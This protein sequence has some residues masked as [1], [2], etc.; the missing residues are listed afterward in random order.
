[1]Q[2]QSSSPGKSTV[3]QTLNKEID[4]KLTRETRSSREMQF[5][6]IVSAAARRDSPGAGGDGSEITSG[7]LGEAGQGSTEKM[8][9]SGEALYRCGNEGCHHST[10]TCVFLR[11]HLQVCSVGSGSPFLCCYHCGKQ[12]RQVSSLLDHLRV[13]GP[14]RFLCGVEGC[15][16]KTTMLHNFKYHMKQDHQQSGYKHI[17]KDP[18]NKDPETQA[19][20]VY[21]K[22]AIPAHV[23]THRKRKNE[24]SIEDLNRIPRPSI[25][26]VDLK[27]Y[28]CTFSSKVRLNLLKHLQLHSKYPNGIP[29]KLYIVD[30]K[31]IP[32]PGKQPVNPVPC[33]HRKEMMFDTMMNLA[34][35]SFSESKKKKEDE[36][37]ELRLKNPIPVEELEAIPKFIEEKDL[38]LCRIDGCNY[39]S[40]DA[41]MLKY[42]I[43]TL[44][45]D[46][47]SFPCPHCKHFIIT[48]EKMS[49]HFRL[50]GDHLYRCGWCPYIA[51]KRN[52]VERHM[53]EKHV[54]K[55]LFDF[56][57]REPDD[58]NAPKPPEEYINQ[59]KD[60]TQAGPPQKPV[61]QCGMCKFS[62][63]T[64]QE[65]VNHTSLKHEIKSQYKCGYCNVRS[66]VRASF[67]AHFAAKH[68]N[69]EFRVLCMYYRLDS[70]D[71]VP[72]G[73]GTGQNTHEPLWKRND[74]ERIKHIRGILLDDGLRQKKIWMDHTEYG[75]PENDEF[76]CPVCGSFKNTC[77]NTFRAHLCKEAN[78]H[79]YQCELCGITNAL[80]PSL[81]AHY[82][83]THH[84]SFNK[85][86][87]IDLPVEDEKEAW[88][89]NIISHQQL[90][91]KKWR[92]AGGISKKDIPYS[93]PRVTGGSPARAATRSA[94]C[95]SRSS[96]DLSGGEGSPIGGVILHDSGSGQG[97]FTC[98]T[99]AV[100]CR[101]AAG[102]KSHIT[103]MHQARFK[104]YYCPFSSNTETA[105]KQHC[106]NK[107]PRLENK[108]QDTSLRRG[109]VKDENTERDILLKSAEDSFDDKGKEKEIQD[110]TQL[111]PIK[112][113]F[114]NHCDF[115]TSSSPGYYTHMRTKH[116]AQRL[117]RCGNC[118]ARFNTTRDGMRHN[119]LKHPNLKAAIVTITEE[120]QAS[121]LAD[122]DDGDI[123]EGL[124]EESVGSSIATSSDLQHTSFVKSNKAKTKKSF[125]LQSYVKEDPNSF[126]KETSSVVDSNCADECKMKEDSDGNFNSMYNCCHCDF[127][128]EWLAVEQHVKNKHRDLPF[129]V[130]KELADKIV[131]EVYL[132]PCC[133][134]KETS[135]SLQQSMDHW[136][137]NH[138]TLEFKPLIKLHHAGFV[139]KPKVEVTESTSK[140]VESLSVI[141]PKLS[142]IDTDPNIN[143]DENMLKSPHQSSLS[144]AELEDEDLCEE[145]TEEPPTADGLNRMAGSTNANDEIIYRCGMCKKSS[146]VKDI[147]EIHQSTMH[148]GKQV[149]MREYTR[150]QYNQQFQ[151][152]Y[153]CGH[154]GEKGRR[155]VMNR[156]SEKQHPDLPPKL[157]KVKKPRT[158]KKRRISDSGP[159]DNIWFRCEVCQHVVKNLRSIKAHMQR[160]HPS[161][162][163][164]Y[165]KLAM[166]GSPYIPGPGTSPC[167]SVSSSPMQ[168]SSP[169]TP[170]PGSIKSPAT[171]FNPPFMCRYCSDYG[172]TLQ[173]MLTHHTFMHSHLEPRI[174][175][176]SDESLVPS[177]FTKY[178]MSPQVH[179]TEAIL[180]GAAAL[181]SPLTTASASRRLSTEQDNTS[182]S[183]VSK[184]QPIG[185]I[186]NTARKSFPVPEKR[187]VAMKST[188]KK[189]LSVIDES[190]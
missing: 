68:K 46:I 42:H 28:H 55:K 120:E 149:V 67:D 9:L 29:L 137:Q 108:V 60:S 190:K 112:T 141:G 106:T 45:P 182:L 90:L 31:G 117:Y 80:L 176:T 86:T 184:L 30:G 85:N 81:R 62:S 180:S 18:N 10:K 16:H 144:D 170:V 37:G 127:Q 70:E 132:Y 147:I 95:L 65:M 114:C 34:G 148:A 11:E 13:H 129:Q 113:L 76:V 133:H 168:M 83:K 17:P 171:A 186:K 15:N 82:L 25:S 161:S 33:L 43:N 181:P 102:L 138:V 39:I 53:K 6:A 72:L 98:T 44:H 107:H 165:T 173:E 150:E 4:P 48:V 52:R 35:S 145:L 156:H 134:C 23:E 154:C 5:L 22:D 21:P 179:D 12:C 59:V 77:I 36:M 41:I 131:T 122:E 105:V 24:Y 143:M 75:S 54:H 128:D 169:L 84:G 164:S 71:I 78:Y 167:T 136:I 1:N 14:K 63:V 27:C 97:R 87:Y 162:M 93:I 79:R 2:G 185:K 178:N 38:H 3:N 163:D 130:K 40:A 160:H 111:Q 100:E 172:E 157:T 139:E 152:E 47:S 125:T 64:Q 7:V 101:T 146:K 142:K 91:I 187:S 116:S 58:P 123:D 121:S 151:L 61:W 88:V 183:S 174:I 8:G 110:T 158:P 32:I 50:H 124:S 118:Q 135:I 19:F 115:S 104:C 140:T 69:K 51:Y 155:V 56:I 159:K 57:L 49:A 73:S 66:S 96:E 153:E 189:R 177:S 20:V 89:E 103:A 99:C 74:P 94:V 188:S 119:R 175:N 26:Y 109:I 92:S 166:Q 126:S